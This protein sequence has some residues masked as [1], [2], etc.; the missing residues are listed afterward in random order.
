M[1]QTSLGARRTGL[2]LTGFL[3]TSLA[4]AGRESIPLLE[5]SFWYSSVVA[6][7]M[8]FGLTAVCYTVMV[9]H[10]GGRKDKER[11]RSKG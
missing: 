4:Q 6:Y 7:L 9:W 5:R 3:A 11:Q 1:K 8:F 10:S 2:L